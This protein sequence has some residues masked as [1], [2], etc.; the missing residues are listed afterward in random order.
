MHVRQHIMRKHINSQAKSRRHLR[1]SLD[2][3]ETH[4]GTSRLEAFSDGIFTIAATLLVIDLKVP[5]GLTEPARL[6][7]ALAALWPNFLSYAMSFIYVGIFW[8]HHF[9]LFRLFKR[10]DHVFFKIN[11]LFL[12]MISF[13]PFPTALL[14][15][16]L[17]APGETQRLAMLVYS[18]TLFITANLFLA[19]WVYA[20]YRHRLIDPDLDDALIRANTRRYL[21]APLGYALSFVLSWSHPYAGLAVT[22]I[23]SLY[24]LI[25]VQA[26][27]FG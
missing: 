20:T 10:T 11:I 12:M 6:L 24:Y 1:F 22:L 8:S 15:E 5:P 4:E 27:R 17:Q 21:L 26:F 14:A 23:I 3:L 18:G 13:L 9:R 16:Y 19:I 7:P 2:F 25:P